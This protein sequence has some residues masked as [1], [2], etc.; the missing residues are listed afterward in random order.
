MKKIIKK[1]LTAI[2]LIV[3]LI[4]SSTTIALAETS[5]EESYTYLSQELQNKIDDLLKDQP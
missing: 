3:T 1:E 2:A 5:N 4:F